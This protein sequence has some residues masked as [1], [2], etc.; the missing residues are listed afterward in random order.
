MIHLVNFCRN[1]MGAAGTAVAAVLFIIFA[2]MGVVIA[3]RGRETMMGV[4]SVCAFL[5]GMLLGAMAGILIFNSLIVMIILAAVLSVL[6]MVV[7]KYFKS[8]GYFIGIS[9]LGWV[10]AFLLTSE[11]K[12][13]PDGISN[14]T[15]L[16]IDLVVG[17]IMG[18]MAASRSKITISLVT[19]A[20]GAVIAATS[21][22]AL[23]GFYFPD[24]KTWII[25]GIIFVTGMIVQI[26]IY[27]LKPVKRKKKK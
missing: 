22:L 6:L 15:L 14:N 7:V 2:V 11:M 21:S 26:R 5:C 25:A 16:F 20:S 9:T 27:D 8:L 19:A 23:I 10:L 18:I 13:A 12:I 1:T 24:I 4:V 17:V 3:M